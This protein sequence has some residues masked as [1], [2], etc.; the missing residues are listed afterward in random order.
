MSKILKHLS[1]PCKAKP[2]IDSQNKKSRM[3][4]I[5]VSGSIPKK[6]SIT[7]KLSLKPGRY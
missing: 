3:S 6:A 5:A 7:S 2:P 4:R 1:T